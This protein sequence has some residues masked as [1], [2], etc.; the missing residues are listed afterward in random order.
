M[1]IPVYHRQVM[2]YTLKRFSGL[3]NQL[4]NT[5]IGHFEL[6]DGAS[7]YELGAENSYI[8]HFSLSGG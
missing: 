3:E 8:E 1:Y 5:P 7:T 2:V 4:S 6:V